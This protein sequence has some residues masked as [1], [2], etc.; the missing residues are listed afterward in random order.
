MLGKEIKLGSV[1]PLGTLIAAVQHLTSGG[2]YS[3]LHLTCAQSLTGKEC[4]WL[5]RLE[6]EH[7]GEHKT[8]SRDVSCKRTGDK[9]FAVAGPRLWNQ[10]P[11]SI[12]Q[13]PSL[14]VFKCLNKA[15][16]K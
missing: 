8:K 9:A 16:P 15:Y 2:E 3:M 4:S 10:L 6:H 12:R 1:E 5:P 7:Y 14:S 11:L 13:A